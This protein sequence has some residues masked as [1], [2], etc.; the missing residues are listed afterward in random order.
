MPAG[1]LC[2][3]G[4]VHSSR[5]LVSNHVARKLDL[6]TDTTSSFTLLHCAE[7][8]LMARK[9][10]GRRIQRPTQTPR[11]LLR[12]AQAYDHWACEFVWCRR[13]R[14]TIR[15]STRSSWRRWTSAHSSSQ[16]CRTSGQVVRSGLRSAQGPFFPPRLQ[17]TRGGVRAGQA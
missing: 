2:L 17:V 8:S 1:Q 3:R 4:L 5:L 9:P 10:G 15:G 7:V 12:R 6:H 14:S 11:R 13:S 16:C